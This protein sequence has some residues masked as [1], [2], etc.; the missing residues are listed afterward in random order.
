MTEAVQDHEPNDVERLV[1]E[2]L[3]AGKHPVLVALRHQLARS[4]VKKREY[5]GKG[6]F[7]DFQR[8]PGEPPIAS[9]RSRIHFGDVVADLR[10]VEGGAGFVIFVDDGYLVT[11]EGYVFMGSW[12][13]EPEIEG[14]RYAP[15]PRDFSGLD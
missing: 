14:L 13:D 3:L 9:L 11:L 2:K 5:S 15:E 12:P 4:S 6:F 7:T 8:P 1:L 10:G